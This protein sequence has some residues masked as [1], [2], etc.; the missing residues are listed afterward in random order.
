MAEITAKRHKKKLQ[1]VY[2]EAKELLKTSA[3]LGNILGCSNLHLT[4]YDQL[5]NMTFPDLRT[6]TC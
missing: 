1:N 4:E 6:C 2:F 3:N 5:I